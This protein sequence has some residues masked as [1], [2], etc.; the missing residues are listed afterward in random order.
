MIRSRLLLLAFAGCVRFAAADPGDFRMLVDDTQAPRPEY[1]ALQGFVMLGEGAAHKRAVGSVGRAFSLSSGPDNTVWGVVTEAIN[2]PSAS[3]SVVGTES[4]VVNMSPDNEGELR[5]I[6]VVFKDR[7][8]SAIDDP[9]PVVG[10]NRYNERSA[11]L[12]VSSQPRSGAGEYA[13]WQAGIK[14]AP[15]SLDRSASVPYAAAIDVSEARVQ[16][17]LYLLVWRCGQVKCGLK[18]TDD[19]ATIVVDIEYAR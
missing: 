5:G 11:A 19:G 7:M 4:A 3:G 18:P 15:A 6:D 17:P 13:G 1:S 9:V 14:F 8:D 12:Y 2:F 10:R 16:A